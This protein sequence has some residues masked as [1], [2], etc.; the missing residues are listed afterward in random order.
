MRICEPQYGNAINLNTLKTF[1]HYFSKELLLHFYFSC[2]VRH[3]HKPTNPPL[4]HL[5]K[6]T[7]LHTV[8]LPPLYI[9]DPAHFNMYAG[10]CKHSPLYTWLLPHLP[11][12]DTLPNTHTCLRSRHK[13]PE[14]RSVSGFYAKCVFLR[15]LPLPR[16]QLFSVFPGN[17]YNSYLCA[18]S[19]T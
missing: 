4:I 19:T 5:N 1:F 14:K 2:K 9:S 8:P 11:S 10:T 15:M 16:K 3:H 12:L 13:S 7:T 18:N 17:F 6:L